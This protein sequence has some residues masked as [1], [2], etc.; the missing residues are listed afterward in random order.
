MHKR[1]TILIIMKS[2]KKAWGFT[3][4]EMLVVIIVIG[5]LAGVSILTYSGLTKRK[6]AAFLATAFSAYETAIQTYYAEFGGYPATYAN[7]NGT[8]TPIDT[9]TAF[10]VSPSSA[11]YACLGESYFARGSMPEN[12]CYTSGGTVFASYRSRLSTTL[13]QYLKDRVDMRSTQVYGSGSDY[14]LRGIMY[15]GFS[16]ASNPPNS[17]TPIKAS[18][19]LMYYFPPPGTTCTSG[20]VLDQLPLDNGETL[21]ACGATYMNGIRQ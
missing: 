14:I 8:I 20:T 19:A 11:M 10:P 2:N 15:Y 9:A 21:D 5:I 1:D 6:D 16:S 17:Y 4:V 12:A 7:V 3:L 13:N 18:T